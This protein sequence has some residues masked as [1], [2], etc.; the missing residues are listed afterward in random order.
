MLNL[1]LQLSYVQMEK[2]GLPLVNFLEATVAKH[3]GS[4]GSALVLGC[5]SGLSSFLLTKT[6]E[7]VQ[8][9]GDLSIQD[10]LQCPD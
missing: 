5:G 9:R 3:N 2:N 10:R 7:K 1:D 8:L 6:F 4:K